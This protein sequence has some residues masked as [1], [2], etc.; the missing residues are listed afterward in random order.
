MSRRMREVSTTVLLVIAVFSAGAVV[1]SVATAM[2]WTD[3][4][5][6]ATVADLAAGEVAWS[7]AE[8]V[9]PSE[10]EPDVVVR[11]GAKVHRIV[12]NEGPEGTSVTPTGTYS[13]GGVAGI[14]SC[15]D[16]AD[17][18][19][20][21]TLGFRVRGPGGTVPNR[22]WSDDISLA[23]DEADGLF[24]DRFVLRVTGDRL[25]D[26]SGTAL[27]AYTVHYALDRTCPGASEV[28][29]VIPGTENEVTVST[30][31]GDITEIVHTAT[32][33]V[34]LT[35]NELW[36]GVSFDRMECGLVV[37]APATKGFTADRLDQPG[38]A[39][40]GW[41]GGFPGQPHASFHFELYVR[42]D[43]P[44]TFVGYRN[45]DQAK[46][47]YSP[48]LAVQGWRCAEDI[49]LGVPRCNLIAYEFS[50]KEAIVG[51]DLRRG[52]DNYDPKYGQV[53]AGTDCAFLPT[54][55]SVDVARCELPEPVLLTDQSTLWVS[56]RTGSSTKGPV[57]TCKNAVIGETSNVWMVY[58][59][60][61][62]E[63][64]PEKGSSACWGGFDVTLYC[65]GP[66]P[67]GACC[68]MV[69][70]ECAGGPDDGKR[71][72]VNADC[73]DPGQCEAVC[74]Q[75]PETNCSAW[76]NDTPTLWAEGGQCGPVCVDSPNA[77]ESCAVDADCALCTDGPRHGLPCCP[78]TTAFCNPTDGRC[79]GGERDGEECCPGGVCPESSCSGS[80][81]DCGPN[82]GQPCTRAADC[83]GWCNQFD[84]AEC[85]NS[86]FNRGCGVAACCKPDNPD[87]PYLVRCENLTLNQCNA[88]PPLE[89]NRDYQ[90][91]AYCNVSGQRCPLNLC[92]GGWGDCCSAEPPDGG[93]CVGGDRD[94]ELCDLYEFPSRCALGDWGGSCEAGSPNAGDLCS[95][96]V[97]DPCGVDDD[98]V[99]YECV[100][101]QCAGRRRPGCDDP[102]C[103]TDVCSSWDP[104][105]GF[106]W[107]CCTER[108]DERC[109]EKAWELCA[110]GQMPAN[111]ECHHPAARKG[112]RLVAIPSMQ[113]ADCIH[114]TESP[115]DPPYC[116][117]EDEPGAWGFATVWYKF[118]ATDTSV[119]LRTCNSVGRTAG[120]AR[121]SLVAV[122][123]T[124]D[125]DRGICRDSTPCSV[126]EGDCDDGSECVFD[127]EYACANLRVAGCND[128]DPGCNP[129]GPGGP[130]PERSDVCVGNLVPGQ[131]YYAMVAAKSRDNF[132]TLGRPLDLGLYTLAITSPCSPESPLPGLPNDRCEDAEKLFGEHVAAPF[133]LSGK[134][135]DKNPVTFDCPAPPPWC[136]RDLVNDVWYEWTAPCDGRATFETCD[137]DNTP[138]T[139]LVVYEGCSCP[140]ETPGDDGRIVGC[141]E[142]QGMGCFMGSKVSADVQA[143]MCY[144]L[145]LGGGGTDRT[146]AGNL[147]ITAT[148]T[149][150]S[151]P[152][153]FVDPP[154]AVVD[155][156]QPHPSTLPFPAQGIRS[157]AVQAS[158]GCDDPSCWSLC[159][160]GSGAPPGIVS[161]DN[162]V[163][164][165][166]T[167]VVQLDRPL[168]AGE[169]TTVTYTDY[170]GGVRT[171][172]TFYV[173]P[174]NV[175]GD[176]FATGA[177][178]TAFI[179]C[180]LNQQ[181][182][183]EMSD[184]Q[185]YRCDID[186]NGTIAPADLLREIDLINGAD[187]HVPWIDTRKPTAEG[188]CPAQGR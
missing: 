177:D 63:W 57:K 128:N 147:T 111:D 117:H 36:V 5:T 184:Q 165:D 162:R 45:T 94:G 49:T 118:F 87:D 50:Y 72:A 80:F 7:P 10:A 34:F 89:G 77:G 175:D 178:V 95:L 176:D 122:Y 59:P 27:G 138:D 113:M 56:F 70:T 17:A 152:V 90:P 173:H 136:T 96:H 183:Q 153:T 38:A 130:E 161:V 81:C 68:D 167:Y 121:D 54:G 126:S 92:S 86:P 14:E 33:S 114:A 60:T 169:A 100:P 112:A 155:A 37:G 137:G 97:H 154:D 40:N 123:A 43:P 22:R 91:G 186:H 16:A 109:A 88:L 31:V 163:F 11:A 69:L 35:T 74:R 28:P 149:C 129:A 156:R 127:E 23:V 179:D 187:F 185:T 61:R 79:I 71:C 182:T 159:E 76:W 75:L 144:Q 131:L 188:I 85:V 115:G 64:V 66:P 21:N 164:L 42:D 9:V 102:F 84:R 134:K 47:P 146:P 105:G 18:G 26:G 99:P 55:A 160:T 2:N 168:T 24:L 15:E 108:W 148:C 143:D 145:R 3:T 39:C 98:F 4:D 13:Y 8:Q 104:W 78:G 20:C 116:C 166:G 25:Q 107:Y 119:R 150:A 103:C 106:Y 48:G 62:G 83:P 46:L 181:C 142:F 157:I 158:P 174:G 170:L 73:A 132:D 141:S 101:A 29:L 135:F 151:G 58:D 133:D 140:V 6:K 65:A 124:E 172:G 125:P 19:Y 44:P 139:S 120:M 41:F 53:I 67:D 180:C 51:A 110:C 30:N 171:T 93:Y 12:V 32:G 82:A 52:L 1:A